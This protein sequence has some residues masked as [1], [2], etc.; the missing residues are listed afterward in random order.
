VCPRQRG[1]PHR[2]ALFQNRNRQRYS[3]FNRPNDAE[4]K[5]IENVDIDGARLGVR[6][7]FFDPVAGV[8]LRHRAIAEVCVDDGHFVPVVVVLVDVKERR[9]QQSNQHCQKAD[10]RATS[11]HGPRFWCSPRDDVNA[12]RDSAVSQFEGN[13][14]RVDAY[15]PAFGK[16]GVPLRCASPQG[17][18]KNYCGGAVLQERA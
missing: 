3:K 5:R 17:E 10:I 11:P 16:G 18:L 14:S 13:P 15:S 2:A 9:G 12:V 4:R 7:L 6:V 8:M 1:G